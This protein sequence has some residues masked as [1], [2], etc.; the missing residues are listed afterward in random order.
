MVTNL[1]P[2]CAGLEK[3]YREAKTLSEKA[4]ALE[5]YI[6]VIPKHKGPEKLLQQLKTRHAK[7]LAQLESER[8]RRGQTAPAGN[9]P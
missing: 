4:D 1:P 3:R 8:R 6:A 7:I 9:T 2:Q 5:E